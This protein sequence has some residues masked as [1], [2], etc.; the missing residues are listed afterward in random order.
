MEDPTVAEFFEDYHFGLCN[1]GDLFPL[2]DLDNSGKLT[3]GELMTGTS[4]L[5]E[6]LRKIDAALIILEVRKM[7]CH[8][9]ALLDRTGHIVPEYTA[10][11]DHR[12]P[13]SGSLEEKNRERSGDGA[14]HCV[15]ISPRAR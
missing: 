13:A 4:L 11:N 9:E 10:A 6:P 12:S 1:K 7:Q 15:W 3:L 5:Q 14:Q 2:L 8:L